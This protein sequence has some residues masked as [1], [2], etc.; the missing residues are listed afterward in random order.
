V[1]LVKRSLKWLKE[2]WNSLF[3]DD[4]IL[5]VTMQRKEDLSIG[6]ANF[7]SSDYDKK[8]R[9]I[10]LFNRRRRANGL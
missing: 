1:F 5:F 4:I 3:L 9:I 7:I 2:I 8:G 10:S 6:R